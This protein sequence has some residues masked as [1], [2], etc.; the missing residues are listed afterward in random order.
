MTTA[1]ISATTTSTFDF[2]TTYTTLSITASGYLDVGVDQTAVEGATGTQA[3]TVV[4]DGKVLGQIYLGTGGSVT[5]GSGAQTSAAMT[6]NSSAIDIRNRIGTVANF[7]SITCLGGAGQS[8]VYLIGGYV[9]N[10]SGAD[11]TARIIGGYG[12]EIR[13]NAGAIVNFGSII[14]TYQNTLAP[15]VYMYGGS[16]TNGTAVDSSALISGAIGM[17]SPGAYATVNNFGTIQGTS[18]LGVGLR[19]GSVANGSAVDRTAL[20]EG[21]NGVYMY[22]VGT[23]TNAGD[24]RSE[25]GAGDF[26]AILGGGGSLTNGA[27]NNTGAVISGYGGVKMGGAPTGTNLGVIEGLGEGRD[28]SGLYFLTNVGS[29]TNG[30]ARDKTATIEGYY[31]AFSAGAA[32]LTNYGTIAGA[33]GY[34]VVLNAASTLVVEQ[35]AVFVGEANINRGALALAGDGGVGIDYSEVTVTNGGSNSGFFNTLTLDVLPGAAFTL[36]GAGVVASYQT[37]DVAGT[38]SAAGTLDIE[39]GI[40]NDSGALSGAGVLNL[41]EGAIAT[42]SAGADL[43]IAKVTESTV[44]GSGLVTVAYFDTTTL[45]VA[46][47]WDQTA[48]SISAATGDRV[49]FTGTGD[50]F[51]GTL[52][53][54]GTIGFT[55]G[56]DTLSATTLSATS[57][58]ID[59]AAVTLTGTL[60]LTKTLSVTSTD[61]TIATAGASLTGGGIVSLSD[62]AANLVKGV[63]ASATLTNVDDK[64]EGAGDV[65]DGEMS[66]TNDAGGTID[67]YLGVA[68]TLN[69]GTNTLVNAGL[70]ESDGTGGLLVSGAADNTGTLEAIK[71]TLT[72]DGA[73]TGAGTVKIAGG[74]ADF[75]STFTENVAFTTA[76]G[77]LKLA[78]ATTYTGTITGFAKTSITSLDFTDIAFTGATVSYSGTTASG[79]LTVKSGANTAKINLTGD[80]LSS[81]FT[82]SKDA[83]SGTIVTD[84]LTAA[85]KPPITT[86]PLVAAMAGFGGASGAS[87]ATGLE[88]AHIPLI[89][90]A[91]PGGAAIA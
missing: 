25:G 21:S 68:L 1:T 80:Y 77:V 47:V 5:N 86:L 17:R 33:S 2:G 19:G 28:G 41:E 85:V 40:F 52:T 67:A 39:G 81:T 90:L 73:V 3:D 65:G 59:G 44:A 20:I 62:S 4:N 64:I 88:T 45:T 54:A 74:T 42:F 18:E 26:G 53:G 35:N 55:G 83:G 6:S 50:T 84:P 60:A 22:G 89:A 15:G 14:S 36:S 69:L 72:V 8:G 58:V 37:L 71:G 11:T 57:E 12:V 30:A 38:L 24:I 10:G 56:T 23:V 79:V 27:L 49:N 63:S 76:G 34:S 13:G 75:A 32:T 78:D 48:G 66:V 87:Y 46:S 31:G 61:L 29:F 51:S 82:L 43:T 7:G 70:I 9:T 91:G 16:L